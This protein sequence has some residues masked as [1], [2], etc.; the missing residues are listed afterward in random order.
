LFEGTTQN[1][2]TF[3]GVYSSDRLTSVLAHPTNDTILFTANSVS[4]GVIDSTGITLNGLQV[5][6]VFINDST[7]T[8]NVS[9]SDLELARNGSGEVILNNISIVGN[10]IKNNTNKGVVNLV[11]SGFGYTKFTGTSGVVIPF[12]GTATQP[13]PATNP[14]PV[15][16][17]R[18]NTDTQILETWDGNTYLTSMGPNPPITPTEFNDLLLEY[19]I[20]FG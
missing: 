2:V 3:N 13:D 20:I 19:T 7:I 5:D 14:I 1:T 17:T 12:G 15:G 9:N 10:T 11:S 8:T 18:Y 16:D 4:S 6:D